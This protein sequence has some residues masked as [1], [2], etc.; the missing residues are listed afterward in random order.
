M[1][2]CRV[3]SLV[4]SFPGYAIES[5]I[6]PFSKCTPSFWEIS[7]PEKRRINTGIA[8]EF[9][10]EYIRNNNMLERARSACMMITRRYLQLL[11]V[12][13]VGS[14]GTCVAEPLI[15]QSLIESCKLFTEAWKGRAERRDWRYPGSRRP[16]TV[17]IEPTNLGFCS[18]AWVIF[19]PREFPPKS[20]GLISHNSHSTFLEIMIVLIVLSKLSC[21]IVRGSQ[22]PTRTRSPTNGRRSKRYHRHQHLE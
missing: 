22:L 16:P 5:F 3:Y 17:T 6:V 21:P 8:D 14:P 20:L 2:S 18:V 12:A 13:G 4:P 10:W 7:Y 9:H 11:G 15:L 19:S 1:N